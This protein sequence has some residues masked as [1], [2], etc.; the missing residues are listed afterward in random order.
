MSS[1]MPE[2]SDYESLR[3][4][5]IEEQLTVRTRVVDTVAVFVL[6]KPFR[7]VQ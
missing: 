4:P 1:N 5:V 6:T 2:Y 7:N 3:I